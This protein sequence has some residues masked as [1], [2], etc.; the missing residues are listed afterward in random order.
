MTKKEALKLFKFNNENICLNHTMIRAGKYLG[1]NP[2]FPQNTTNI[3]KNNIVKIIIQFLLQTYFNNNFN[4]INLP[5]K[6]L[7]NIIIDNK[8]ESSNFSRRFWNK[9]FRRKPSKAKTNDWNRRKTNIMA[10]NEVIF[11]LWI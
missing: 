5:N 9:N 2:I 3:H 8:N 7:F 11:I 6:F 10:Y 4:T 1:D